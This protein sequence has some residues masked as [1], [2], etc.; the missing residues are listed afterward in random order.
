MATA[1]VPDAAPSRCCDLP[2]GQQLQ[3][4]RERPCLCVLP[5]IPPSSSYSETAYWSHFQSPSLK[6]RR[7]CLGFHVK[8]HASVQISPMWNSG[9]PLPLPAASLL[10]LS[11]YL[12]DF[13]C[14]V[15][16]ISYLNC[17]RLAGPYE[18]VTFKPEHKDLMKGPT[19]FPL[20]EER[21]DPVLHSGVS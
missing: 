19:L 9:N 1:S 15:L 5:A 2:W 20:S 18:S 8:A 6:P 21:E 4:R 13:Y 17:Q 10:S 11:R 14:N 7:P 3:R 16:N 12:W